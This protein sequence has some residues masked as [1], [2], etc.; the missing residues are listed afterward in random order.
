[1]LQ[2]KKSKY[3]KSFQP[4]LKGKAQRGNKVTRGEFGLQVLQTSWISARQIEAARKTIV[5]EIK[6]KGKLWITI[7]P[8]IPVTKKS[9]EVGMGKGKGD[10]DKYIFVAK[11]GRVV[12]ELGGVA[13]DIAREALRKAGQK[14]PVKTK[15]IL[16]TM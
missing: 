10:V 9:G 8:H 1:M 7:F 5:R 12:F 13:E 6:R 11:P 3:R 15:F 16:R 14:L 4:S 2:P